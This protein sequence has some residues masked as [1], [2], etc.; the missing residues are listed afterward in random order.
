[1]YN[2]HTHTEYT[3]YFTVIMLQF[4]RAH[5]QR[6]VTKTCMPQ[7][8][9][10]RGGNMFTHTRSIRTHAEI[11]NLT[12]IACAGQ[13]AGVCAKTSNAPFSHMIIT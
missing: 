1:M 7:R 5:T 10:M 2:A 3:K 8:D 4:N 11:I 13:M 6:T 12:V 9:G